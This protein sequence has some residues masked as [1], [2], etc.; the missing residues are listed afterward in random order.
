[1]ALKLKHLR[2]GTLIFITGSL[3]IGCGSPGNS[4]DAL[5]IEGDVP[6]AYVKRPVQTLGNPT[7]SVMFSPGGDLFMRGQSSPSAAEIN[8]TGSYTQG[9]G[10]VSDPEVSY[11]GTKILFSM[12]GPNDGTFNVWE[13]DIPKKSL[14]RIIER[15]P[16]GDAIAGQGNDV[17]PAYLSDGR[18]VFTSDRQQESSQKLGY[19]YRDE[20]EREIVTVLHLMNADGTNIDQIS[21]NQSHDRNPTVLMTGEIMYSRWDHVGRRNQFS[22]FKINP[23]GTD[24]FVLYGAHSPGNSYLHPREMP[25]RQLVS[26]LMPLSGTREGGSLEI[27]DV[28]NFSENNDPAVTPTPVMSTVGLRSWL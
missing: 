17:D 16:A 11:D 19:R 21:F 5:F 4:D 9:Q 26:T 7:D 23:D 18:I 25:S 2:F 12:R 27:I 14:R 20:Y 8:L 6:I 10:D 1:M 13:Y 15:T 28:K 22:V 3:L 24:P